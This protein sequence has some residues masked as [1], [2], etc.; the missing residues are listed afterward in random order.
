M[1]NITNQADTE[2]ARIKFGIEIETTVPTTC[3][4]MVGGYHNGTAVISGRDATTGETIPAPCFNGNY[5]KAERDGSIAYDNGQQPCEFVSPILY[6]DEG[7]AALVQ[8]LTFAKRIG[9][10][11]NK[12]C[13][14]HITVG[15]KSVIGTDDQQDT[16]DFV[17]RLVRMANRNEWAIYAQTGTDRHTNR[18]CHR[19]GETAE[20]NARLMTDTNQDRSMLALNCGRGMVNLQKAF[21]G[22]DRG[23]VEFRAFAG[24]LNDGKVFHHLATVLGLCRKSVKLGVMPNKKVTVQTAPESLRRLWKVLGWN[25]AKGGIA[26]GLFGGLHAKMNEARAEALRMAKKFEE[27]YPSALR[28]T[29][30][31]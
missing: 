1:K 22:G 23:A 17:R 11:V 30:Q 10:K 5:W 8:F 4:F 14:C 3:G 15:I 26:H 29:A 21:R 12:S 31:A 25:S 20:Q 16:A 2:A 7:L 9:A 19:L 13:G 6:G 28:R 18:Y 27:R 24:T